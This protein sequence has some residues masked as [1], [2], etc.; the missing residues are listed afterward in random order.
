MLTAP[1][2]WWRRYNLLLRGGIGG[3][4]TGGQAEPRMLQFGDHTVYAKTTHRAGAR[5][6]PSSVHYPG[7]KRLGLMRRSVRRVRL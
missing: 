4:R 1:C 7:E 3:I 2:S 6:V 5:A